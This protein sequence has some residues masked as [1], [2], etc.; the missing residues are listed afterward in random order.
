MNPVIDNNLSPHNQNLT[1]GAKPNPTSPDAP[2]I[3]RTEGASQHMELLPQ[4][5]N[6]LPPTMAKRRHP[7]NENPTVS[8]RTRVAVEPVTSHYLVPY[9]PVLDLLSPKYRLKTLT[10]MPSTSVRK[11]VDKAL[12]HLEQFN[13]W[14]ATAVPGVVFLSAKL[15]A[16]SKLVTIAGLVRRRVGESK[17]KWYQYNI[18]G[19]GES[20]L[21]DLGSL[22][23]IEDTHID[24]NGG[25]GSHESDGDEYFESL[26]SKIHDRAVEPPKIKHNS[27][28][29][30]WLSRIPI[31]ELN[32]IPDVAVQTNEQKVDR[33]QGKQQ[34]RRP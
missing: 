33:L 28:I 32:D 29:T 8:K 1:F 22:S 5:A 23:V 24:N 30:V 9:Q 7:D 14:D 17:Q 19:E 6:G 16:A 10:V 20:E 3:R 34:G 15:T 13:P 27:Y 2:P 25:D 18:L 26:K 4:P 11:H 21:L 12:E 31:K